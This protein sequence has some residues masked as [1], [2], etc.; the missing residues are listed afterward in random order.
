MSQNTWSH[1]AARRLVVPLLATPVTPNHLTTARLLTGLAAVGAFAL[2]TDEGNFWG[3]ILFIISMFL[4]RAD[5][6]LARVSG[7]T[8]AAGHRYDVICDV[9]VVSLLFL[10]IGI[11]A[12]DG[13]LA[14]WGTALGFIAGAAI[15]FIYRILW[16]FERAQNL[17]QHTP[18]KD[19]R[20]F[21]PDDLLYLVGP[22]AWFGLFPDVLIAAAV[23]APFYALWMLRQYRRFRIGIQPGEKLTSNAPAGLGESSAHLGSAGGLRR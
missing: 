21:D 4:D 19:D 7:K 3:G 5:G 8:S 6:E 9:A 2:G 10:G 15:V 12:R 20:W 22:I 17:E 11:G 13:Y 18:V 23:G 14:E 1:R 16:L